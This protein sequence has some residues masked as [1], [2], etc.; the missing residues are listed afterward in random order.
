MDMDTG[1]I[2]SLLFGSLIQRIPEFIVVFVGLVFCFINMKKARGASRLALV[3]LLIFLIINIIG[4]FMPLITTQLM[5]RMFRDNL[6][7]YGILTVV[8]GFIFSLI[9]S[10]GL[11]LII[12]SVWLGRK[13]D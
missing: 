11:A 7:N 13:E 5:L 6:T 12:Y 1:N 2:I 3:G 8:I 4:V 10:V 9:G